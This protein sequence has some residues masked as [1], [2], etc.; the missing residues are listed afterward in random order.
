MW[1]NIKIKISLLNDSYNSDIS[2][3]IKGIILYLI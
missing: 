2:D 3:K 1:F